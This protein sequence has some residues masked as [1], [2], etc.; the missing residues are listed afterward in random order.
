MQVSLGFDLH[1]EQHQKL[2]VPHLTSAYNHQL[3]ALP[4][5]RFLVD[6]TYQ[7]G[8][9]GQTFDLPS[10]FPGLG[11]YPR[12][13]YLSTVLSCATWV[14]AATQ[15]ASILRAIPDATAFEKLAV[16]LKLPEVFTLAEVD[17][18]LVFY[19]DRPAD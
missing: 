5:F 8:S 3:N 10:F 16:S 14:V 15:F 19:R 9:G 11:F 18:E 12:V 2:A 4:L 13:C 6:L 17:Q 7:Y 1:T